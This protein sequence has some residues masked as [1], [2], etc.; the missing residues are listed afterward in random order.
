M[1]TNEKEET[2]LRIFFAHAKSNDSNKSCKVLNS[3]L[4]LLPLVGDGSAYNSRA[5]L[6]LM[7]GQQAKF[8]HLRYFK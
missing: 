7:N 5:P 1:A 2:N 8:F 4:Y 3:I 6:Q